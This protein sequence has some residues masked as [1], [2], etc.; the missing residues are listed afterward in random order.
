MTYM[1]TTT[2]LWYLQYKH[3]TQVAY[4]SIMYAVR[5]RENARNAVFGGMG[6]KNLVVLS[7]TA[8]LHLFPF[9]L[10]FINV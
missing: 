9:Y 2:E 5:V 1:G 10:R 7:L 8:Q 3:T 6:W 4:N